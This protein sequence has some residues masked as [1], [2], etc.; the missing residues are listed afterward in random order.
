MDQVDSLNHRSTKAK[1]EDKI[2]V[3][4][5]D[6]IM[7]SEVIR[8]DIGQMVETGDSIDKMEV[9]PGMNKIIEDEILEVIQGHI[10]ISKDKRVEESIEIITEMKVMAE[11]EIG[12][13]L[14]KGHFPKTLVVIETIGVL[15]YCGSC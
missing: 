2:E 1:V 14:E 9:D 4:M 10:K 13:G 11:V 8:I 3:T 6:A 15:K 12:T 7:I 5:I